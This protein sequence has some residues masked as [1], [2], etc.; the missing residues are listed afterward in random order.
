[1]WPREGLLAD[2]VPVAER[3]EGRWEEVRARARGNTGRWGLWIWA[4]TQ[5]TPP[6]ETFDQVPRSHEEGTI[7]PGTGGAGENQSWGTGQ[8]ELA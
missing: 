7:T 8:G 2:S 3:A 1:M 6:P 4:G 5:H